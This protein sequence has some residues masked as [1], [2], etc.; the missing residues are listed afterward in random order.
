MRQPSTMTCF[1]LLA[2]AAC[3][4]LR[5]ELASSQ[6]HTP[7]MP[8][9]RAEMLAYLAY[10]V[11]LP[12]YL[13]FAAAA[14]S[15]QRATARLCEAPTTA[16]LEAAQA[17]WKQAAALWKRSEAFQLDLTRSYAKS[18]G[19]WPTRPRRLRLALMSG[20]PITPDFVKAMGVAAH[21][22]SAMEHLLFDG[23]FGSTAVLRAIQE[24][25]MAN[26]WCPYLVAMTA[27]RRQSQAVAQLWRPGAASATTWRAGQGGATYPRL[28]APSAPSSISSCQP[29]KWY[30][31]TKSASRC[32]AMAARPGLMLWRP[33]AAAPPRRC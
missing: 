12:T 21:G 17:S 15:L 33:A 32:V 5:F 20:Q 4:V 14:A 22:L 16:R 10:N 29:S 11:M 27:S 31:T 24:G 2:L 30:S 23:E 18:I 1:G 13:D 3:G 8:F 28:M 6:P 26:R 9:D 25:P 19:F 7:P